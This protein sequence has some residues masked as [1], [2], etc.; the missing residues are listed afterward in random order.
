MVDSQS[1]KE[2][3]E[4]IGTDGKHVGTV[5]RLE[6][7]GRFI[8]LTREDDGATHGRHHWIPANWVDRVAS[9]RLELD[10]SSEDARR[11]WQWQRGEK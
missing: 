7:D 3:M 8:K 10:R 4:V 2:H 5:D 9:G 11:D 6:D 1:I